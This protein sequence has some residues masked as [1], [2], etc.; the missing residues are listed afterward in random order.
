MQAIKDQQPKRIIRLQDILKA[1]KRRKLY[2]FLD[3][4]GNIAIGPPNSAGITP[5][6]LAVI[7]I[8]DHYDQLLKLIRQIPSRRLKP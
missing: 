4:E 8:E 3:P 6:L 7:S 2:L 5:A 1:L